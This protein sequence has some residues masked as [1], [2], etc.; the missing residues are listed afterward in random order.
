LFKI[1]SRSRKKIRKR[2][3]TKEKDEN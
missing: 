2:K 1:V 3:K